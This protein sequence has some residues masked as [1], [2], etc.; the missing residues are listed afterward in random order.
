MHHWTHARQRLPSGR[1]TRY[2]ISEH[3]NPLGVL[4]AMELMA[5][6]TGFRNFMTDLL[7][8][9]EYRAFRWETPALDRAR[10]TVPFEFVLIDD[11]TLDRKADPTVF[12]SYF[13]G[14]AINDAVAVVPNLGRTSELIVPRGIVAP[15]AYPHFAAFLRSAPETQVDALWRCV[16]DTMLRSLSDTPL[17]LSTAGAGVAWLHVRV[18]RV[19]KYYAHRPYAVAAG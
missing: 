16:A 14:V 1:G 17:W 7:A 9:S 18:D 2:L 5:T 11:P 12:A 19:P 10:A 3:S 13:A 6:D 8:S 15:S 4:Q